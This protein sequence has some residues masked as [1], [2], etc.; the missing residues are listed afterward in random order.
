VT[1]YKDS[2]DEIVIRIYDG[3]YDDLSRALAEL[4][5]HHLSGAG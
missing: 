2:D 5:Y 1:A 4:Y 3:D